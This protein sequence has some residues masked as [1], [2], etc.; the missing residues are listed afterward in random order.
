M[1]FETRYFHQHVI[2]WMYKH[3]VRITHKYILVMK[4]IINSEVWQLAW[5]QHTSDSANAILIQCHCCGSM[6]KTGFRGSRQHSSSSGQHVNPA[7]AEKQE[8]ERLVVLLLKAKHT[9]NANHHL[10]KYWLFF[11]SDQILK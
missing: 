10:P 8:H 4:Y 3:S 7:L 5:F 1:A 9:A 2:E 11:I 6:C